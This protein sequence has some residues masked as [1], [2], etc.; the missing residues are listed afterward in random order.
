[1][2]KP[3]LVEVQIESDDWNYSTGEVIN[4]YVMTNSEYNVQRK[5][6][7]K[8][9]GSEFPSYSI[10]NIAKLEEKE[11]SDYMFDEFLFQPIV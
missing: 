10:V 3:F 11:L 2:K 9:S 7:N 5:V 1:M 6:D 8:W 4:S